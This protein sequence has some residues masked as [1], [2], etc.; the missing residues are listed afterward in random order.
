MMGIGHSL[1]LLVFN[2]VILLDSRKLSVQQ[3]ADVQL[4]KWFQDRD[5]N[6][7]GSS[8]NGAV[9]TQSYCRRRSTAIC[10]QSRVQY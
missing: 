2:F 5:A 3:Y 7:C 6:P 1:S 9:I 10:H 8:S 4:S